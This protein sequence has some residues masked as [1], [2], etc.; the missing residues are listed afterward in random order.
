[1]SSKGHCSDLIVNIWQDIYQR[2]WRQWS[3]SRACLPNGGML[4]LELPM[5]LWRP[6]IS[7]APLPLRPLITVDLR[8]HSQPQ[9]ES[10]PLAPEAVADS[11]AADLEPARDWVVD[12]VP[13]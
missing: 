11:P 4:K 6:L 12:F 13:T 7:E 1:V 8:Q 2:V 10:L 5:T 3:R 9:L